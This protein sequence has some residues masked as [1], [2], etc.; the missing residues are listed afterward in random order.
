MKYINL[1]CGDNQT[2][3]HVMFFRANLITIKEQGKNEG[4][5]C[6][7]IVLQSELGGH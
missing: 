2:S 4:K 6:S 1:S 7:F 5:I 3:T